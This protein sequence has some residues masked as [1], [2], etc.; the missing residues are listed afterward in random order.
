MRSWSVRTSTSSNDVPSS[1]NAFNSGADSCRI[2]G[3]AFTGESSSTFQL[4]LIDQPVGSAKP[5]SKL[6]EAFP[7]TTGTG[8]TT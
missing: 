6:S 4:S 8:L 5:A 1:I 3:G 2:R 7:W